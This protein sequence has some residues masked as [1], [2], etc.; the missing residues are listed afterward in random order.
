M[1]CR[2]QSEDIATTVIKVSSKGI[3]SVQGSTHISPSTGDL[4]LV[5]FVKDNEGL[6]SCIWDN[7]GPYQ[8]QLKEFNSK[9]PLSVYICIYIYAYLLML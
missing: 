6:Y 5:D 9:Y 7:H 4:T 2:G 3:V 1:P 8:V